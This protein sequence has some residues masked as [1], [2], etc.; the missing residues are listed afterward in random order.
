MTKESYILSWWQEASTGAGA[1]VWGI[2]SLNLKHKA[3]RTDWKWFD[4]NHKVCAEQHTYSSKVVPSKPPWIGP[5]TTG[6]CSNA[7]DY[8]GVFSSKSPQGVIP[9]TWF[10]LL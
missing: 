1:E 4:F 6:K 10:L 5:A 3:E 2:S 9:I 8:G 7:Q